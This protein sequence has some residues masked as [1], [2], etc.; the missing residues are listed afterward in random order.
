MFNKRVARLFTVLLIHTTNVQ[1][2]M[3]ISKC[4]VLNGMTIYDI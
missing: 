2:L 3:N 1:Q 4:Q